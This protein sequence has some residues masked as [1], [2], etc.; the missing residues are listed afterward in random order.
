MQRE[1]QQRAVYGSNVPLVQ[2][3]PVMHTHL[4]MLAKHS[5]ILLPLSPTTTTFYSLANL[6]FPPPIFSLFFFFFPLHVSCHPCTATTPDARPN[7]S[8]A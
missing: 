8:A 3:K 2:W 7:S 4:K 1:R 5:L 6:R